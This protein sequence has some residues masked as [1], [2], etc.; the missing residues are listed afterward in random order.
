[1]GVLEDIE[2]RL[3]RIEAL[4]EALADRAE[5]APV[6]ADE[7]RVWLNVGD[8]AEHLGVSK[9]TLHRWRG[10]GEGPPCHKIGQ[11]LRYDRQEL[12]AWTREQGR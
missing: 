12:D 2:S 1:M 10:I 5:P 8:A 9:Q 7:G 4:V 3:G 11:N 6:S